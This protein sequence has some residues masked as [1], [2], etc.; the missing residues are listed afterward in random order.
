MPSCTLRC[1]FVSWWPRLEWDSAGI[2]DVRGSV[3]GP[4]GLDDELLQVEDRGTA[5]AQNNIAPWAA[6]AI[7]GRVIFEYVFCRMFMAI[8]GV[9]A[10][11]A[12][13]NL[14]R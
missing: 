9:N 12:A 10:T 6:G 11:I 3:I 5:V 7:H 1:L 8:V 4:R 13:H 2:S 14:H